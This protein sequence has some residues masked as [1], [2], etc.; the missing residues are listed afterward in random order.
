[1]SNDRIADLLIT[2]LPYAW[3]AKSLIFLILAATL[4]LQRGQK[5]LAW[6]INGMFA[7][8][9]IASMWV[10]WLTLYLTR[11]ITGDEIDR[12]VLW[13]LLILGNATPWMVTFA[14][15]GVTYY[16][17]RVEPVETRDQRD[18]RQDAT[19]E[20]LDETSLVLARRGKK[21]SDAG[22]KLDERIIQLGADQRTHDAEGVR[23]DQ[24][25]HDLDERDANRSTHP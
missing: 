21:L 20:V 18:K 2:G 5:P 23:Q 10:A 9:V 24:R 16:T 6:W 7:A 19:Q 22:I 12:A 1:M 3:S 25:E 14:G 11:N 13:W 15:L 8:T 17:Y 4:M